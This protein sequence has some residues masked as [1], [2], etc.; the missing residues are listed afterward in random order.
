VEY[1]GTFSVELLKVEK[2]LPEDLSGSVV[3]KKSFI[4]GKRKG[5]P[6]LLGE[7]RLHTAEKE[8][9]ASGLF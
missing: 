8:K 6:A 1:P 4:V 5:L 2:C 9:R 7:R 3:R